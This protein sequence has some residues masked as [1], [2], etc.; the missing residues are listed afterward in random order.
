MSDDLERQVIQVLSGYLQ[1]DRRTIESDSRL[2]E[3]LC[4][5]SVGVVE[6]VMSINEAFGID[7]PDA[8]VTEWRT[9]GD[10]CCLVREC[11]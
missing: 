10:I 1:V 3:D 9:V 6:I 11:K 5:D 2:V 7:L 8:D 4:V